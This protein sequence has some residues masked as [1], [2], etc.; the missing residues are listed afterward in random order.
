MKQLRFFSLALLLVVVFYACSKS[1]ETEVRSG[2]YGTTPPGC[3]TANM[4]FNTDI[5]PILQSNCYA[6]HSNAT[7]TIS[8]TKLEEYSDLIHHVHDGDVLGSI[9]HASGFPAMPQDGPKLS[10]CDIN[11]IKAWIDR[12]ALDN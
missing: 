5:K 11:K 2:F 3:D 6:C 10:D 9:T 1:N 7:Y 8:G 12:G 4:S